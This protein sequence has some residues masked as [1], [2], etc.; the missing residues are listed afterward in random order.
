MSKNKYDLLLNDCTFIILLTNGELVTT[1]NISSC[2][3]FFIIESLI[4]TSLPRQV[5]KSKPMGLILA[6]VVCCS[7][8]VK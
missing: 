8:N 7:S 6:M 3:T 5:N 1:Y 2:I 4:I